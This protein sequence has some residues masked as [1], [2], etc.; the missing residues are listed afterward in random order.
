MQKN[1]G[2]EVFEVVYVNSLEDEN[3]GSNVNSQTSFARK[4]ERHSSTKVDKERP[5]ECEICFNRFSQKQ[6]LKQ[7]I[8]IHTGQRPFECNICSKTF[9]QQGALHRHLALHTEEDKPFTCHLC[10]LSFRQQTNLKRHLK[11]H[12]GTAKV[13]ECEICARRFARKEGLV[14]HGKTHE[15]QRK[16]FAQR[17]SL[18]RLALHTESDKPFTLPEQESG[19]AADMGDNLPLSFGQHTNVKRHTNPHEGNA[20][21]FECDICTRR[22]VRKEGLVRHEKTHERQLEGNV[23]HFCSHCNQSFANKLS[24]KKH[25]DGH[26]SSRIEDMNEMSNQI[27]ST[28]KVLTDKENTESRAGSSS[29]KILFLTFACPMCNFTCSKSADFEVHQLT[30]V[31]EDNICVFC[32]LEFSSQDLVL[33]H[34]DDCHMLG[35]AHCCKLC[36]ET[37]SQESHLSDHYLVHRRDVDLSDYVRVYQCYLCDQLFARRSRIVS[38][39]RKHEK[40]GDVRS[41]GG[42]SKSKHKSKGSKRNLRRGTKPGRQDDNLN[43]STKHGTSEYGNDRGS[44]IGEEPIDSFITT[45]LKQQDIGQNNAHL[46]AQDIQND[47]YVETENIAQDNYGEMHDKLEYTPHVTPVDEMKFDGVLVKA[48]TVIRKPF[49]LEFTR[50]STTLSAQTEENLV[51]SVISK[52][53]KIEQG[54]ED[55]LVT[56]HTNDGDQELLDKSLYKSHE[57]VVQDPIDILY[58][59]DQPVSI[60]Y[61]QD[62]YTVQ[63]I[64][65]EGNLDAQENPDDPE[66]IEIKQEEFKDQVEGF[67]NEV[68]QEDEENCESEVYQDNEEMTTNEVY[69]GYGEKYKKE[70]L[71]DHVEEHPEEIYDNEEH[72]KESY[73]NETYQKE[74]YENETYQEHEQQ[75]YQ[76]KEN[77]EV[78]DDDTMFLEERTTSAPNSPRDLDDDYDIDELVEANLNMDVEQSSNKEISKDIDE[79]LLGKGLNKAHKA[80]DIS[81]DSAAIKGSDSS[82]NPQSNT[83]AV[84]NAMITEALLSNFKGK[85]VIKA[86]QKVEYVKV[87]FDADGLFCEDDESSQEKGVSPYACYVCKKSYANKNSM[88]RHFRLTHTNYEKLPCD[89]CPK[90]F[91]SKDAL[92]KHIRALHTP[93]RFKCGVCQRTFNR[94]DAL[95]SHARTH[96]AERPFACETCGASFAQKQHLYAH[97]MKHRQD[98]QSRPFVCDYCGKRFQGKEILKRHC[99]IHTNERNFACHICNR[100]FIQKNHLDKHL[101]IHNED[102]AKYPCAICDKIFSRKDTMQRHAE[103]HANGRRLYHCAHCDKG[104]KSKVTL[105]LH[106]K[107]KICMSSRK[108]A[109]K[110]KE[111]GRNVFYEG[112][113][114]PTKK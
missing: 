17:G 54:S 104:L 36:P 77:T 48:D 62:D 4:H 27:S 28:G 87:S 39:V 105:A 90:I 74:V 57:N 88:R 67:E 24:L 70:L 79:A 45:L 55:K 3:S 32:N 50:K 14:R 73:E 80:D 93:H 37:F 1:S 41:Q 78:E 42:Y 66:D 84:S 86:K 43:Q 18:H 16:T 20:K 96:S 19:Q 106:L 83:D 51:P 8:L 94:K 71:Q 25:E 7:H 91:Q 26:Y 81:W 109:K 49:D 99:L 92:R 101:L 40:R 56:L 76:D 68:S 13:F 69:Q 114:I 75:I 38:H 22:F 47:A 5:F 2:G 46:E 108:W 53:I 98:I 23:Q 100:T 6:T 9:T 82:L 33:A 112:G 89:Q 10:P 102:A 60:F 61:K 107:R 21:V 110:E 65:P 30:H 72:Q 11:L 44:F 15:R 103:T 58:E 111:L 52:S 34:I 31:R 29:K 12:E 63:L 113:Y 97:S 85:G 64:N 35:P 59:N 95:A